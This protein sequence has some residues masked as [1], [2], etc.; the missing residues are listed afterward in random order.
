MKIAEVLPSGKTVL[1]DATPEEEK[2]IK[3][4][5]AAAKPVKR[6]FEE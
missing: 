3:A 4:V 1:R 6:V 5:I 2:N